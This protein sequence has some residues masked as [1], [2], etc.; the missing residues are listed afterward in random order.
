[1][2]YESNTTLYLR[3]DTGAR[4]QT[5]RY[6]LTFFSLTLFG[7]PEHCT[8]RLSAHAMRG[9]KKIE[10]AE[11]EGTQGVNLKRIC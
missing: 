7:K 9:P 6:V 5:G 2:R 10:A 3:H 11:N 8:Q 1:M 4:T